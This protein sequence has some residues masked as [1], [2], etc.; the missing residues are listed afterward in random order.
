M[1]K[2]A[3]PA[4]IAEY[5]IDNKIASEPASVWW[6]LFTIQKRDRIIAAVIKRYLFRSHKFGIVVPKTAA[7]AL[8][9]DKIC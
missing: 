6:V 3:N 7:E 1:L 5:V 2:E 9:I 4:E 8:D